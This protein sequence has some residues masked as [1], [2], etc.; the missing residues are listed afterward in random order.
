MLPDGT[1][2]SLGDLPPCWLIVDDV[3]LPKASSQKMMVC[4]WDYDYVRDKNIHCLRVG[5][6]LDQWGHQDPRGVGTMAQERLGL[7][8]TDEDEVPH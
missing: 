2:A 1:D 7:P 6:L 5:G 3:I 4:W 8:Q